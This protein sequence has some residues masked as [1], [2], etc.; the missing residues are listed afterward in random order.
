M[1][2]LSI[3]R[4][5]PK[6]YSPRLLRRNTKSLSSVAHSF[7]NEFLGAMSKVFI[8]DVCLEREINLGWYLGEGARDLEGCR[9]REL[10]KGEIQE[11]TIEILT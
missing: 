2:A 1:L 6:R 3:L 7:N 9:V 5:G 10:L 8:W 11:P 4:N